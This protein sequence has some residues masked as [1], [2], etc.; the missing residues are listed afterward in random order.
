VR[1]NASRWRNRKSLR[2]EMRRLRVSL[3]RPVNQTSRVDLYATLSTHSTP[4]SLNYWHG[5]GSRTE[6][7]VE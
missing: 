3:L 7:D 2:R 5:R 6:H 1:R 4:T